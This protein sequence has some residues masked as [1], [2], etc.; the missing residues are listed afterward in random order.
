M[1]APTDAQADAT[2][3]SDL[4]RAPTDE[5]LDIFGLTHTGKVRKTNQDHFLV[6][7][8]RRLVD[9]HLTS[10]PTDTRWP[11]AKRLAFMA[12]VADGVGSTDAGEEASRL[13]V[14]RVTEY[15]TQCIKAYHAT[16][17]NRVDAFSDSIADAAMQ[18]HAAI[19]EH[20]KEEDAQR[21][22]ATTLTLCEMGGRQLVGWGCVG[23]TD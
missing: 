3:A 20:S 10:L 2:A 19:L 5:E 16:D 11:A 1:T 12:M 18:V 14:E 13:A 22:M 8:L 23:Y 21:R 15:V 6:A 17:G 9:I 7:S 4:M